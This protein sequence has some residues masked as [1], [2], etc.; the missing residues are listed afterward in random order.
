M[1]T[2]AGAP[3]GKRLAAFTCSG[4]DVAMLAD[5][6]DS[7]GLIFDSPD[8]AT[9][10]SLRQWLP[11]IATVGNPLDYTTPLWGQEETLKNVF[12]AAL[13]PG[14]DAALLVQD[15]PP[16]EISDD[17]PYYQADAR[18]FVHA[19]QNAGIPAAVCSSL[20]EN[21]DHETQATLINKG[22]APLQGISEAAV[23]ISASAVF[24]QVSKKLQS[25]S[26]PFIPKIY[27]PDRSQL[28][29]LD[30]WQGKRM[31]RTHHI[32]VPPGELVNSKTAIE[33]ARR[34][35][36]P[37]VLKLVTNQ[38]PHKTE[39]GVVRLN[40]ANE[41]E[42]H[43]A[44]HDV[45][46]LGSQVLG[47]RVDDQLLVEKMLSTTIAELLVGVQNDPQFGLVMTLAGGG[48]LVELMADSTTILLPT[49]RSSLRDALAL[50]KVMRLLEGYRN[51]PR[52]DI[53]QLLDMLMAISEMAQQLAHKLI[54]MDINP[55]LV[56][57][58]GCFAA[59]ALIQI[60]DHD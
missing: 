47:Q 57:E 6:A 43:Q 11:D 7:Q 35:G 55:I 5:C 56:T 16:V 29:T 20:P 37:V 3:A 12:S 38:L 50:L 4:G 34:I 10:K 44:A 8:A 45:L 27:T 23:A 21:L 41:E 33:T 19:T 51:C 26:D 17:R 52:A 13:A 14:Y 2:T 48:T 46:D 53:D 32:P 1:L 24:G 36:F 30:E 49:D 40:L 58:S 28:V 54:E 39:A 15:Y 42:V 25:G 9:E 59:D 18:A 60:S 22:I 31:L